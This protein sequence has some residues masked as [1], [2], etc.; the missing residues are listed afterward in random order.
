MGLTIDDLEKRGLGDAFAR[1]I[2]EAIKQTVNGASRFVAPAVA[3]IPRDKSL[4]YPEYCDC[5]DVD[6]MG[7][8]DFDDK[9]NMV[10]GCSPGPC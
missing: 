2:K 3:Q 10:L 8:M 1:I 7:M 5:V 4:I 9:T 6:E